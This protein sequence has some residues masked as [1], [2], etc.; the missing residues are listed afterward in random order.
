MNSKIKRIA[1][2]NPF[3]N[4][5]HGLIRDYFC[6]RRSKFGYCAEDCNLIPPLYVDTPRNLFIYSNSVLNHATIINRNAKFIMK[7]NSLAA[8]GLTVVTGN[9]AMIAGRAFCTITEEEKPDGLDEDVVVEED[10][11]LG[12]NVTLLSGVVIG[13]GSIV[14]AGA[15][16]TRSCCPYSIIGGVPA[17]HIKFKWSIDDIIRHE[18]KCYRPEDRLSR[19]RLEEFFAKYEKQV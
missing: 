12:C 1:K 7:K 6:I 5:L 19:D 10:V 11:W 8:Y 14:A 9:H 18:E 4:G 2:R 3:I 16:V 17:R 15:V 13:R